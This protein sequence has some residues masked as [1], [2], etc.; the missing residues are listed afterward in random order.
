MAQAAVP[1]FVSKLSDA[2]AEAAETQSW[3]D[4]ALDCGYVERDV[5]DE[6][7]E[8]YEKITGGLVKMMANPTP[9]GGPSG[10]VRE[11]EAQ[12]AA[13]DAPSHPPI[14]PNAHPQP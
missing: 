13:G 1:P 10:L 14:L 2:D 8:T 4:F 11:E 12:Y 6:L 9:W 7:N 5:Y 3:L